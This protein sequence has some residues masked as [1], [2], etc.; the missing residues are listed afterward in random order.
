MRVRRAHAGAL[1]IVFDVLRPTLLAN[2]TN[3]TFNTFVALPQTAVLA[4][5]PWQEIPDLHRLIQPMKRRCCVARD[6]SRRGG[7]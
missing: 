7:G 6:V 5:P 3:E 4:I 2:I 1:G